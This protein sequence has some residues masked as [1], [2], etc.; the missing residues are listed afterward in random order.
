M[1]EAAT[2]GNVFVFFFNQYIL[3]KEA[4]EHHGLM[5]LENRL[6]LGPFF[7]IIPSYHLLFKYLDYYLHLILLILI[8]CDI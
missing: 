1:L 2:L 4:T 7:A 6:G 8:L 5:A 3:N